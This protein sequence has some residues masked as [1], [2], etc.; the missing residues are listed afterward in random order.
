MGINNTAHHPEPNLRHER[1]WPPDDK[2]NAS[3][4][5]EHHQGWFLLPG[6]SIDTNPTELLQTILQ[7][8]DTE[9]KRSDGVIAIPIEDV[10]IL[11]TRSNL[12]EKVRIDDIWEDL[13]KALTGPPTD[14][15]LKFLRE[16][17]ES[18]SYEMDF[19]VEYG[20]EAGVN[21]RLPPDR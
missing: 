20:S 18:E 7:A 13:L 8:K 1:R 19:G 11:L 14:H 21:A 2:R 12:F 10:G 3:Q 17:D 15:T 4:R 9:T 5:F 16:P 6:L